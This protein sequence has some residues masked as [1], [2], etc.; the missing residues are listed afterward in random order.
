MTNLNQFKWNKE[1]ILT[2][3][4]DDAVV[5]EA[6]NNKLEDAAVNR[7]INDL[8]VN[9]EADAKKKQKEGKLKK[10]LDKITPMC[11]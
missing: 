3:K 10:Q 7:I 9:G 5:Q 6:I 8:I 2:H 11:H 1:Y 4:L